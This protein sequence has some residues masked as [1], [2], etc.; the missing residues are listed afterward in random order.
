MLFI[1]LPFNWCITKEGILIFVSSL[2]RIVYARVLKSSQKNTFQGSVD[3]IK[4]SLITGDDL[5]TKFTLSWCA[6]YSE[7]K[8]N[9]PYAYII[10]AS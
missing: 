4:I 9:Y 8:N 6:L 7:E 10:N 2:N 1:I 3:K 5:L